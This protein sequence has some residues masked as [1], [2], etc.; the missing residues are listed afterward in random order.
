MLRDLHAVTVHSCSKHF[1]DAALFI[2]HLIARHLKR[3]WLSQVRLSL[4]Q[5]FWQLP[6]QR[7]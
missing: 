7:I 2:V 3:L 1:M 5:P 4:L 6:R